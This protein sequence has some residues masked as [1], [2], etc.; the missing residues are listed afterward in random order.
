MI[1]RLRFHW[2][3]HVTAVATSSSVRANSRESS[4]FSISQH[5]ELCDSVDHQCRKA[6]LR[7]PLWKE[8]QIQAKNRSI[9][10]F[11]RIFCVST[12]L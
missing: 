4:P 10:D 2:R 6:T 3:V 8:L 7:L 11:R 12:A 1:C 9:L 5:P